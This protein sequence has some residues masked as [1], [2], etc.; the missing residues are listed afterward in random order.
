MWG[1]ASEPGMVRPSVLAWLWAWVR[2]RP[3]PS[4]RNGEEVCKNEGEAQLAAAPNWTEQVSSWP[5]PYAVYIERGERATSKVAGQARL[6]GWRGRQTRG[7]SHSGSHSLSVTEGRKRQLS[8]LTVTQTHKLL[9]VSW[10]EK[11]TFEKGDAFFLQHVSAQKL[12]IL[13][14]S[15]GLY[16]IT[17][18]ND[19][20]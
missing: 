9:R 11:V 3:R 16:Q 2:E 6:Q 10:W 8:P 4:E 20:Q 12:W 5:D 15:G 14:L 13:G 19:R 18:P 1:V 17:W 7:W